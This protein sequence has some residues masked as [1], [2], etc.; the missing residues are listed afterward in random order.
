MTRLTSNTLCYYNGENG[1]CLGAPD[2]DAAVAALPPDPIGDENIKIT[3]Q[4][5]TPQGQKALGAYKKGM[6]AI[7]DGQ[8]DAAD[9]FYHESVH[10]YLDVFMDAD[11]QADLLMAARKRFGTKDWAETEEALAEAFIKYAKDREGVTGKIK[12]AFDTV[13]SRVS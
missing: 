4:I 12:Q 5:L 8:A 2:L 6:I 13:L 1:L 3:G 10:K 9:T 11:E 7:L